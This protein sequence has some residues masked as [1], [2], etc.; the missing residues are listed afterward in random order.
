LKKKGFHGKTIGGGFVC[1]G[2]VSSVLSPWQRGVSSIPNSWVYLLVVWWPA[3]HELKSRTHERLFYLWHGKPLNSTWKFRYSSFWEQQK[4]VSNNSTQGGGDG[5]I[6][7]SSSRP[8][9]RMVIYSKI[10][11][12]LTKL[13]KNIY[14]FFLN[15]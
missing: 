6:T 5:G 11:N 2:H 14:N 15:T 3:N 8:L 12:C 9:T 1:F 4:P 7:N 10:W 13:K